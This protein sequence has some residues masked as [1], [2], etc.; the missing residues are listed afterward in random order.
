MTET[1]SREKITVIDLLRLQKA[2]L[3]NTSLSQAELVA[4]DANGNGSINVL[5]LLKL[6]KKILNK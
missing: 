3:G 1:K 2:I 4:G 6:Q 5:D